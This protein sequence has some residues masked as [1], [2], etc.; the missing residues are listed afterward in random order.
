MSSLSSYHLHSFPIFSFSVFF[1]PSVCHNATVV[2]FPQ[3]QH[4]LHGLNQE[5]VGTHT[6]LTAFLEG[7]SK[8]SE[9][10]LCVSPVQ[11]GRGL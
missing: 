5:W 6:W 10:Q 7:N 3:S 8:P 1:C 4:W 2:S 11:T 9:L